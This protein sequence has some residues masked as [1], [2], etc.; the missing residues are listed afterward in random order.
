MRRGYP[1]KASVYEADLSQFSTL[2]G[3]VFQRKEYLNVL[4]LAELAWYPLAGT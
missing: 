4:E 2:S 1:I 3:S